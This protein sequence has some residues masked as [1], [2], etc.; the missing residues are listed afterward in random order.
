MLTGN[1]GHPNGGVTS[2]IQPC[3]WPLGFNNPSIIFPDGR[4]GDKTTFVKNGDFFD[5]A[6]T[7]KY[8]EEV[9]NALGEAADDR[10]KTE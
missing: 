4:E 10:F 5:A 1:L 2:E 3:G 9:M 8:V 7:G 6:N